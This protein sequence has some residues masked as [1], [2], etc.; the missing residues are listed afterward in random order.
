MRPAS[1]VGQ[2]ATKQVTAAEQ[3]SQQYIEQSEPVPQL[4]IWGD[5]FHGS[6][7]DELPYLSLVSPESAF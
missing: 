7:D 6:A 5:F 1:V 2:S 4:T 3:R